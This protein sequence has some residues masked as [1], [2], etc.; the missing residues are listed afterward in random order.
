MRIFAFAAFLFASISAAAHA[1]EKPIE[2]KSGPG[3]DKVVASCG[4]CHSLDYIG[5][6]SPFLGAAQ[7][8]AEV[9]KMIRI[10]GAPINEADAKEIAEYLK[11]NY[12]S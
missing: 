6:N 12:G 11:K 9:T 2:L 8:D 7:W 1:E 5:M 3:V 10:M 4:S